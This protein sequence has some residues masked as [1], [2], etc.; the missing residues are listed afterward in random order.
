ML[1]S[2]VVK[3]VVAMVGIIGGNTGTATGK[4]YEK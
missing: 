4:V 3:L 1:P 2:V